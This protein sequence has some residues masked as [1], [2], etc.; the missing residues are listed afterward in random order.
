MLQTRTRK[1]DTRLSIQSLI[2]FVILIS[3]VLWVAPADA[4]EALWETHSQSG[5]RAYNSGDFASAQKHFLAAI[6]AAKI[7][8]P[9]NARLG[10]A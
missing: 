3:I 10:R 7:L 8:G 1:L 6:D 4:Q 9:E 2:H 5:E